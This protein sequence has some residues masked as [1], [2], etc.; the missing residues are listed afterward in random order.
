MVSDEE[1]GISKVQCRFGNL[2]F[3]AL[4]EFWQW[5]CVSISKVGCR[6]AKWELSRDRPGTRY[7]PKERGEFRQAEFITA[8]AR[9]AFPS[10]AVRCTE[11]TNMGTFPCGLHSRYRMPQELVFI[12]LLYYI[13]DVPD[14]ESVDSLNFQCFTIVT[15][16]P[17]SFLSIFDHVI[18]LR[19]CGVR[20]QSLTN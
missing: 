20:P 9:V 17:L 14:L 4:L 15:S 3:T 11:Y 2:A 13:F 6:V 10:A 7:G 8:I 12:K 19:W 1:R 16:S 18:K 5:S